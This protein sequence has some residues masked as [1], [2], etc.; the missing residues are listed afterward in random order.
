MS[1]QKIR[2]R[3]KAFDHT[4]LDQSAEKIVETAAKITTA[5]IAP[6]YL[7]KYLESFFVE[8]LKSFGFS[9]IPGPCPIGPRGFLEGIL[10]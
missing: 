10:L 7:P 1:K 8:P 2:I 5:I 9:T 4:I 3:L 6:Q